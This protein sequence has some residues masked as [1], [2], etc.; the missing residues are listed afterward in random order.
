M[1]KASKIMAWWVVH[2]LGPLG[3]CHWG[4]AIGEFGFLKPLEPRVGSGFVF[5]SCNFQ[6]VL[7]ASL[8]L[9]AR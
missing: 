5:S 1:L 7:H 4:V 6:T 8:P 9:S 3:S 2:L